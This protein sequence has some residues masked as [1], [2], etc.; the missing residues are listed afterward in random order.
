M[1]KDKTSL[2]KFDGKLSGFKD[3]AER[4]FE[5]AHLKAYLRGDIRFTHGKYPKD[6]KN[7]EGQMVFKGEDIWYYVKRVEV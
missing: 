5:A 3:K 7:S 6:Y 4:N 2:F 1:K